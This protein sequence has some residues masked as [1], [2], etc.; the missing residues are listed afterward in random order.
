MRKTQPKPR[1]RARRVL[2]WSLALTGMLAVNMWVWSMVRTAAVQR[3]ESVAFDQERSRLEDKPSPLGA[4][5]HLSPPPMLVESSLI[6][7]L[8]IPR[9]G[10][11]GM[12]REGDGEK[13]LG[14]ALG[15]IPGTALPGARGNVGVAGHRD[16]LFRGLG[17][18]RPK[19]TIEF[20]TLGGSYEYQVESTRVVSPSDVAVLR[21]DG[22]EE[23]TLVTCYPFWY[24]GAAPQRFIVKAKMVGS[25]SLVSRNGTTA[26]SGSLVAIENR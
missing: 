6:G 11:H 21:G 26:R 12:V 14:V 7:R 8:E 18:I 24:V 22:S 5:L 2:E 13:T 19:D 1:G 15:H 3:Q 17:S 23:L 25:G 20:E 10:L 16:T 4:A 9:L